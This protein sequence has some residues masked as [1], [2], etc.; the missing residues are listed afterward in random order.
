MS[1][2]DQTTPPARPRRPRNTWVRRIKSRIHNNGLVA[3]RTIPEGTRIIEYV[4]E[5]LTKRESAIRA[6]QRIDRAQRTGAAAVFIF[7]L[8]ARYDIDG[9]VRWNPAR[10][11]NHS[12]NPNC[13]TRIIRGHIWIIALRE[14]QAG[15]DLTYD[16]GYDL[17][18]W[19]EHPCRCGEPNCVGHIVR[20]DQ[21]RK[22]KKILE[23]R[24][25]KDST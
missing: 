11:I 9:S 8:N 16:Y 4:G 24:R 15:E 7:E 22:L 1:V 18:H 17:E 20:R 25:R 13:E 10:L 3:A 6:L 23:K 19:E 5:R 21:H 2:N 12:C 14:I